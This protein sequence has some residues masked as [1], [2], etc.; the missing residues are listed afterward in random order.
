MC[1]VDFRFMK[2]INLDFF[3]LHTGMEGNTTK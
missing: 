1:L 3:L 2:D